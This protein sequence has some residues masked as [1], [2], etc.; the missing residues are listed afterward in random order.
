M[1]DFVVWRNAV[2]GSEIASSPLLPQITS[3]SIVQ[4]YYAGDMFYGGIAGTLVKL[5]PSP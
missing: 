1:N 4:P 3:E 5:M 2:S